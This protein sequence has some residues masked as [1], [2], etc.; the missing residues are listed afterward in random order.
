MMSEH[1]DT[2][3]DVIA[4]IREGIESA[5]RGEL[6]PANQVFEEMRAHYGI[7]RS[8]PIVIKAAHNKPSGE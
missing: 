5:R 8:L 7:T 3:D 2:K 6:K 1:A 4:A